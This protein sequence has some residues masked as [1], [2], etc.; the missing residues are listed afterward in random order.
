MA[1]IILSVSEDANKE[2]MR[3]IAEEEGMNPTEK[4]INSMQKVWTMIWEIREKVRGM[5]TDSFMALICM[6]IEE[7]C[8][9]AQIDAVDVGAKLAEVIAGVNEEKGKYSR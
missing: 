3:Q 1:K 5:D 2:L 4:E 9:E 6:L 7:H 8:L